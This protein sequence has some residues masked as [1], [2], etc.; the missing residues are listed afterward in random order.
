VLEASV[1]NETTRRHYGNCGRGH[2][3]HARSNRRCQ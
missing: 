1:G 3:R 2:S